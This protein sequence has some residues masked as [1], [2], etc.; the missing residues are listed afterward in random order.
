M[1][2]QAEPRIAKRLPCS[3]VVDERRYAGLVLNLSAGGLFIQT[4]AGPRRGASVEVQLSASNNSQAIPV[5][6][7]VVWR[8]VVPPSL[9]AAA[10]GGIGL[11]IQRADDAYYDLLAAVLPDV[12]ARLRRESAPDASAADPVPSEERPAYPEFRVR[13][14]HGA[15]PRSRILRVSAG[16]AEQARAE[17]EQRLGPG[18]RVLDVEPV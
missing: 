12:A 18:W 10:Q 1:H 6:A 16:D 4:H 2:G 14:L 13:A 5:E 17:A 15:G 7:K 9:R 11:R 3:V 8:R